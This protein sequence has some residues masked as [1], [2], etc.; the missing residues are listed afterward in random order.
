MALSTFY[1]SD[2]SSSTSADTIITQSSYNRGLPI[3]LTSVDIDNGVISLGAE[4]FQGCIDLIS[5]TIPDSVTS[6]EQAAF[7]ECFGLTSVY[8]L[9]NAPS[10]GLAIFSSTNANLKVYRYSTKS[11][12]SSTFGGKD[13]LLIDMPSKGLRTFGFPNI[14]SG[15]ISIKKQNLGDGKIK[16]NKRPNLFTCPFEVDTTT[17]PAVNPLN[18]P[19]WYL[20]FNNSRIGKTTAPDG[21][22][23][24]TEYQS[25]NTNNSYVSQGF[26]EYWRPD[27]KYEFSIWA[28]STLG[29]STDGDIINV[30]RNGG[31]DRV[32]IGAIGN[33]TS[34][35]KK[36]TIT[37]TTGPSSSLVRNYIT[38]FFGADLTP[39]TRI[40]LWGAE[41]YRYD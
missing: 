14:S 28:K 4:A 23:T 11:G 39:G 13:V 15:K 20:A 29:T 26:L 7:E 35:W 25:L 37:F 33:L 2:G 22:N 41:M 32:A 17:C 16:I 30:T 40:A 38:A 19:G 36:F 18:G 34:T 6:I 27:T 12:W 10:L 5:V 21:S 8:F 3:I 1:Y 9:G 24:A 31:G